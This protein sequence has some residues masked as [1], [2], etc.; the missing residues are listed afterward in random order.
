ML[1]PFA[2]LTQGRD[3]WEE[4]LRM[5]KEKNK[6]IFYVLFRLAADLTSLFSPAVCV[7]VCVS[8]GWV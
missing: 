7:C 1:P 6:D 3:L 2:E 8:T 5:F 4:L